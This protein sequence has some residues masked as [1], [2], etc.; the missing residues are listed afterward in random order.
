VSTH[1]LRRLRLAQP[2][3][4]RRR[5]RRRRLAPRPAPRPPSAGPLR[6]GRLADVDVVALRLFPG[7]TAD[8]LR[9]VLR[10]PVRGLVLETYGSGNAPSRDPTCSAC[11]AR[12]STRGVVVVNVTQCLRGG[13]QMGAYAAGRALAE[14]GVVSGGDLTAE[15]ALAKLLVLCRAATRPARR[16]RRHGA[17]PGRRAD[18]A[19]PDDP[20]RP[21]IPGLEG[22]ALDH[23]AIAVPT[24]EAATPYARSGWRG[25]P[26]EV[27][28]GQ[29]VARA[30]AARRPDTAIELLAPLGA[31]APVARFLARR[32][33][34]LH[35][36]AFAVDDLDAEIGACGARRAF[37]D[38]SRAR[39][40]RQPRRLPPPALDR[41]RVG[42]A[43]RPPVTARGDP[44]RL[45]RWALVGAALWAAGLFALSSLPAATV[46]STSGGASRARRQGRPRGALRRPGRAPAV[47]RAAARIGGRGRRRRRRRRRVGRAGARA[48]PHA[49]PFDWSPTSSAPRWARAT[50]SALAR[51]RGARGRVT[52]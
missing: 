9:N 11:C 18:A 22:L 51:R 26:D 25:R 5:R 34:G 13:V 21:P 43:G 10:D 35:H 4:A 16:R 44:R 17:R 8:T 42:R 31:D 23:V 28:A 29:G 49:D 40:R 46:R 52:G 6:V 19:E 37:V 30:D 2:A 24:F 20:A 41:R 32:G 36:L 15:A 7:I 39:P 1:G 27:V 48:R 47:R 45:G 12:R 3:A 50:V 38:P 33:P 14:A